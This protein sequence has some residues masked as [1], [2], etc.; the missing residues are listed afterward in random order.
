MGHS[1]QGETLREHKVHPS[2]P[3]KKGIPAETIIFKVFSGLLPS[4]CLENHVDGPV[5]HPPPTPTDNH[6]RGCECDAERR[7]GLERYEGVGADRRS[8]SS[9]VVRIC[10]VRASVQ[11]FR[12]SGG[13]WG[14]FFEETSVV[15]P[16]GGKGFQ[17]R[18]VSAKVLDKRCH[19]I[20]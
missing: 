10:F 16:S 20:K 2:P 14:D 8:L 9:W 19:P 12:D 6:Y 15:F 13:S 1:L 17:P 3:Q 18:K 5:R 4:I 11:G 7:D